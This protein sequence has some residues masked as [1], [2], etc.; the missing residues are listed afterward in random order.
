M[1]PV[2]GYLAIALVLVAGG[3]VLWVDVVAD[4]APVAS[5]RQ[6]GAAPHVALG[7]STARRVGHAAA[8]GSPA[9]AAPVAP[10]AAAS[11][12]AAPRRRYPRTRDPDG[13]LTPDLS[14]FVNRASDRR[15][16]R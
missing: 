16:P 5:A 12:S 1:A 14:D 13:D 3:L 4:A 9:S 15:W 8:P 6:H 2:L 11:A 7:R 10:V